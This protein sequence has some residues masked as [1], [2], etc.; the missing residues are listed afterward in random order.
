MATPSSRVPPSDTSIAHE[1]FGYLWGLIFLGSAREAIPVPIPFGPTLIRFIN[2]HGD[3]ID[4]IKT[5]IQ[6]ALGLQVDAMAIFDDARQNWP[7]NVHT[8]NGVAAWLL[9]Y[10]GNR[11]PLPFDVGDTALMRRVVRFGV[12]RQLYGIVEAMTTAIAARQPNDDQVAS[13]HRVLTEAAALAGEPDPGAAA[14]EGYEA[15]CVAGLTDYLNP[16]SGA[17]EEAR[18][19]LREVVDRLDAAFENDG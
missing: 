9:L 19:H 18:S 6:H 13:A 16:S 2:D 8:M 1:V 12:K 14:R 4:R 17:T 10:S 3:A 7:D 15:W 5:L 11:V